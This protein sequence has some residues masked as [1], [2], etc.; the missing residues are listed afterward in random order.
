MH[1][2][3]IGQSC[4]TYC[5][6]ADVLAASLKLVEYRI[7]STRAHEDVYDILLSQ[8][9]NLSQGKYLSTIGLS[10][11]TM[12][13]AKGIGKT[14]SLKTF[15]HICKYFIP[16]VHVLYISFNNIMGSKWLLE[17]SLTSIIVAL[18]QELDINFYESAGCHK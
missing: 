6:V 3:E 9:I 18:L 16:G 5:S 11:S 7:Y 17:K 14:T 1:K 4:C 10:S 2:K 12:V 15:A 8:S 13:G